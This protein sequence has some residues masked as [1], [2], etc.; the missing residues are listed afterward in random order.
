MK[1]NE[2]FVYDRVY[3]IGFDGGGNFFRN[4]PTPNIDRVFANG[5]VNHFALTANPTLSGTCWGSVLHGVSPYLHRLSNDRCGRESLP[6]DY[7]YPS[8]FKVA[9]EKYPEAVLASFDNWDSINRGMIETDTGVI[10]GTGTDDEITGMICDCIEKNDP[11][12]LFVQFDSPDECGGHGFG[13]PYQLASVTHCD[14]L[15]GRIYDAAE[16]SGATENLLVIVTA[17]HGGRPDG[18]HGGDSDAEK[19]VSYFV[20]GKTVKKGT[21]GAIE[22]RD[23]AS[24]VAYALGCD[25][26]DSWSSRIPD[27][28]FCDA[29]TFP[30]PSEAGPGGTK[31]YSDRQNEATPEENGRRLCDFI[32]SGGLRCYFP[33]D[34]GCGDALGRVG[35]SAEGELRYTEGFYGGAVFPGNGAVNCDPVPTGKD[36]YTICM[37]LNI[38]DAPRDEKLVFFSTMKDDS[39]KGIRYSVRGEELTLEIG[40]GDGRM[41]VH[42][43]P[44]PENFRGNLF[45]FLNKYNRSS[46]ET[47]FYYDFAII[48]DCFSDVI[49]PRDLELNGSVT[50]IGGYVPVAVDDLIVF[51]H[52]ANDEEIDALRRYYEENGR[53]RRKDA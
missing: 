25:Q 8:F 16:K 19:Y 40:L 36:D 2:H 52:N 9:R 42:S 20:S 23:T 32:S 51:D 34:G 4:T 5:A 1:F 10:T 14:E 22:T 49:I 27:G 31:K 30:R 35:S 11:K 28:L 7:P 29:V 21:P 37:W 47:C 44:L 46:N 43:E 12:L 45:H 41:V 18:N 26:P 48:C 50:K 24:V 33:F 39:D 38:G 3:V 15:F 6:A 17:D 13:S 53:F